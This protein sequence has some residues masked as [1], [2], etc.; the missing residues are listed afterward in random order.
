[1]SDQR[2]REFQR[3]WETTRS[4][5]D[6][7]MLLQEALRT[8]TIDPARVRL[9]ALFGHPAAQLV[10]ATSSTFPERPT[11]S[12][13]R[14]SIAPE[15]AAAGSPTVARAMAALIDLIP[16]EPEHATR[17]EHLRALA[18]RLLA[19][20]EIQEEFTLTD[21]DAV[22]AA[23]TIC[24]A[25]EQALRVS[26]PSADVARTLSVLVRRIAAEHEGR[27]VPWTTLADLVQTWRKR[28]IPWLLHGSS[29]GAP[30]V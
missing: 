3:R 20:G 14:G 4:V 22:A 21:V 12:D 10:T 16:T 26:R 2:L 8:K 1:M 13:V 6:E 7:V 11:M 15:I 28:L 29:S 24:V 9:A 19:G 23:Q 17:I 18:M 25:V 30:L 5:D 27:P